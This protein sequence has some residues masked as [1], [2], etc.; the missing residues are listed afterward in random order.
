[1]AFNDQIFMKGGNMLDVM[2][3][4]QLTQDG[5]EWKEIPGYPTYLV[6]NFG[7]VYGTVQNI[8]E[9]GEWTY[10]GYRRVPLSISCKQE[11]KRVSHLVMMA[12]CEDYD[13][14]KKIHHINK[15][16]GDDRLENL[17]QLT[18][19]EHRAVHDLYDILGDEYVKSLDA[20]TLLRMCRFV[21]H[22]FDGGE[23]A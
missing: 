21:L 4:M 2:N 9:K 10:N 13:S 15:N 11:K 22:F 3:L 1:M 8:I 14:K 5:E 7:R 12:F 23:A 20:A 16:R 6:S 19:E 17:L 18:D